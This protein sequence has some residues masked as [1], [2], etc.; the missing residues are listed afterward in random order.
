MVSQLIGFDRIRFLDNISFSGCSDRLYMFFHINTGKGKQQLHD[1]HRWATRKILCKTRFNGQEKADR[2]ALI[3]SKAQDLALVIRLPD[4][5]SGIHEVN[6]AASAGNH[7][8]RPNQLAS[9]NIMLSWL[10][11]KS[12]FLHLDVQCS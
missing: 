2:I 9:G 1:P 12:Q 4:A 10:T 3:K 11:T 5:G 8:F 6:A 7:V